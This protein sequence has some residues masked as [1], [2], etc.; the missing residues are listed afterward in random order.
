M[1]RAFLFLPLFFS[2]VLA[3]RV[4]TVDDL[5]N[6]KSAGSPQISPDGNR[7]AHTVT[8]TDWKQ[9]AFVTH[10]WIADVKTGRTAQLTRGEK[11][12][13]NAQWSPDGEWLAFTSDRIGGKN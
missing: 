10:I 11:S 4:P 5:L 3:Q 13:G 7:V 8:E 1:K 9:D 12:A 6:I 2:F